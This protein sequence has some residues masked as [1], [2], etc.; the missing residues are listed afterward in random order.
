M[1]RFEVYKAKNNDWYWR[2]IASNGRTI[3]DSGEG[4][5]SEYNAVR[6]AKRTKEVAPSA[7]VM[8]LDGTVLNEA[9]Q[10]QGEADPF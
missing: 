9:R 4:Y 10:A 7:P 8:R 5:T 3:A 1:L 2:L 6:A